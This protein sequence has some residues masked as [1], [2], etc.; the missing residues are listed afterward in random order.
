MKISCGVRAFSKKTLLSAAL[1]LLAG[2]SGSAQVLSSVYSFDNKTNDLN[3]SAG[4]LLFGN[5]LYGTTAGSV[6][7]P[8]GGRSEKNP[9]L[10]GAIFKLNT[11]GTSFTNFYIFSPVDQNS[12]TN[13]DGANSTAQLVLSGNTL[14]GTTEHGGFYANGTVF[15]INTDGSGFTNLYNFSAT[16]SDSAGYSTNSDGTEPS[17]GLVLSGS[18]LYGTT[19]G[20]GSFGGGTVFAIQTDGTGFTN[21]YNFSLDYA[22]TR[23]DGLKSSLVLSN[24]I[25]YGT[26]EIGGSSTNGTVFAINTDGTGFTNLHSFS[27]LVQETISAYVSIDTNSDGA[28]PVG[29]L[30]LSG[31]KLYGT[32]TEGGSGIY[33]GSSAFGG[34][35]FAIHTDGTGF[36]NLH[37]FNGSDG[38]DPIA[39]LVLSGSTLYGT[40]QLGGSL[41]SQQDGAV[42]AINTDG[43]GFVT[44]HTFTISQPNSSGDYTNADG[45]VPIG[46]LILS[47]STLYGATENGGTN[48]FGTVFALN[49]AVAPPTI[50]F[51]ASPTNGIVRLAV[52]F[53]SPAVDSGGNPILAWNWNFGDVSNSTS[54]AQNP[55]HTY[56]NA[57]TFL[58][59]LTCINNNGDTVIGSGPAIMAS[60]PPPI[61]FTAKPT[62]GLP[63]LAVQFNC[64]GADAGSNTLVSWNWNFGD[65]S[66]SAVQ[67]PSHTYT[68]IG[69]FF[70]SLTCVNNNGDTLTSSGPAIVVINSILLSGGF[71]TGTFTN[72]TQSGYIKGSRVTT[73][74]TYAHSGKYGAEL[75]AGGTMGFLSQTLPTVSGASYVLSFWLDSPFNFTPNDFQVLW[76]GNV[77][78]DETNLGSVGWTNFQLTVTA[79]GTSSTLQFGYLPGLEFGL[80]DVSVAANVTPTQV[81]IAGISLSGANLVINGINGLS[82]TTYYILTSTNLGQ[83]LSQWTPVAT[84]QVNTNGNFTITATNVVDRAAPQRY[85]ILEVP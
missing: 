68:N 74:S 11:D 22:P 65:G 80:D 3:H 72:W 40:A 84:N 60:R 24:N 46:N 32:A 58:P 62:N 50:Q 13:T 77:L 1:L 41:S 64:P 67:N 82:N 9:G 27:S 63:P 48:G 15:A 34:T 23:A 31:N 47:G 79:M 70:P 4:L 52:Q 19:S 83:P 38:A 75:A 14:Y 56:T 57:A 21:L 26:A 55:T 59:T 78:L 30:V 36:T 43:T 18:T 53:S 12:A 5:T 29:G 85:Y 33:S 54:I 76:N 7:S 39:G 42:F 37:S 49:L 16:A 69:T 35:V 81:G 20:G 28:N 25:L 10:S 73:S 17:A 61:Q 2:A 8:V 66:T 6:Y 71:E 51:T 45:S 44:L